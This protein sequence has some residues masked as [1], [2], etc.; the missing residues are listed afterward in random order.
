MKIL[1]VTPC[2]PPETAPAGVRASELG[3]IWVAEKHEVSIL[4]G[5]P[6]YPMGKIHPGYRSKMWRIWMKED[7]HGIQINRT[8]LIP[9]PNR[10]SWDR[11]IN[12]L[13]FSV[14]AVLRG[15]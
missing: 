3:R 13:S 7:D 2:Y 11:M 8:W 10:K 5:F 15:M 14:S 1:Y 12:F 4:T 6:N 9:L